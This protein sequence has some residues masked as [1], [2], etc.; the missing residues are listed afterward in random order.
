MDARAPL[1]PH[2][3]ATDG[4]LSAPAPPPSLRSAASGDRSCPFDL[5][6]LRQ[7]VLDDPRYCA[8]MLRKFAERSDDF[9]TALENVARWGPAHELV[10]QAYTLKHVAANLSAD[11]LHQCAADLERVARAG[12]RELAALAVNRVKARLRRCQ[13]AVPA[14]IA[15][16]L[17]EIE[18]AK[19]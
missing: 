13:R 17:S 2:E 5:K 8:L 9:V 15:E 10:A 16:I 12:Q 18:P 7:Q 1:A 11:D 6:R 14:A 19:R 3:F 4:I